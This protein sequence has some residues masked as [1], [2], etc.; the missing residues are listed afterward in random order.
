MGDGYHV[1]TTKALQQGASHDLF[2]AGEGSI[3]LEWNQQ[4]AQAAF[5]RQADGRWMLTWRMGSGAESATT[6]S[7][8]FCG[9]A[10]D[11]FGT[12]LN[13][14]LI[15]AAPERD[16]FSIDFANLSMDPQAVMDGLSREGWAA[17][18][19][20]NPQDRLHLR[21]RPDRAA[22]SLGKFHNRTPVQVLEKRRD[23][24]RVSIGLDGHLEGWMMTR[25]LG[26][27]AAMDGVKAAQ[28]D[29]VLK[30]AYL[31]RRPYPTADLRETAPAPMGYPVWIVGVGG[32]ALYALLD[33]EGNTGYMPQDW[34]WG[35]NGR[36]YET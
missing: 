4:S 16:L 31:N 34:F 33:A 23:W 25:Y 26:F 19:N 12:S 20:P 35:G 18:A 14:I 15:G 9:L 32:D 1:R 21:T 24:S 13:G 17:V 36:G 30:E 27:G 22:P 3:S 2:H 8:L 28:P 5:A 10:V 11:G 6:Y 29:K 7:L